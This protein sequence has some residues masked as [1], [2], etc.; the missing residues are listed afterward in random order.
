MGR[1]GDRQTD[2]QADRQTDKQADRQ[3]DRWTGGWADGWMDGWTG[4]WVNGWMDG[5]TGRQADGQTHEGGEKQLFLALPPHSLF[6]TSGHP[7]VSLSPWWETVTVVPLPALGPVVGQSFPKNRKHSSTSGWTASR[8]HLPLLP[9]TSLATKSSFLNATEKEHEAPVPTGW[10][11]EGKTVK[12]SFPT[13]ISPSL[14]HNRPSFLQQQEQQPS[15]EDNNLVLLFI[16]PFLPLQLLPYH[17]CHPIGCQSPS[18]GISSSCQPHHCIMI[19]IF[20]LY[21]HNTA[22]ISSFCTWYTLQG[23]YLLKTSLP[24]MCIQPIYALLD[25]C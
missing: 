10:K 18:H 4:R 21:L 13:L 20:F 16:S 25:L 6:F 1:W 11:G 24:C 9:P 3:T 2:K 7:A 14:H 15:S 19:Y 23:L 22:S 5:W 17:H 12:E 8:S